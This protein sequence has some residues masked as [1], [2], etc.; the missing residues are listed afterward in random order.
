MLCSLLHYNFGIYNVAICFSM[1]N[2]DNATLRCALHSVHKFS[3]DYNKVKCSTLLSTTYPAYSVWRTKCAETKS[4]SVLKS[5]VST[6][7]SYKRVHCPNF[8]IYY[9]AYSFSMESMCNN[10]LKCAN[11]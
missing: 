5:S 2:R 4:T 8:G 1:V 11:K 10:I 3:T 9:A 6:S 7:V